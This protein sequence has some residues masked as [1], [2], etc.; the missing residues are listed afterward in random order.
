MYPITITNSYQVG[1]QRGKWNGVM[2]AKRIWEFS[3]FEDIEEPVTFS[4]AFHQTD[5]RKGDISFFSALMLHS[6][7]SSS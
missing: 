6:P 3:S 5:G 1:V 2:D 7:P 4:Q